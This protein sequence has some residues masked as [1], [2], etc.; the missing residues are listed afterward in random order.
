MVRPTEFWSEFIA[1]C[2]SF[3]NALLREAADVRSR[4][5]S[6]AVTKYP[7]RDIWVNEGQMTI[8]SAS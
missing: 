2:S 6:R 8:D 5:L 3:G 1:M 7:E 4:D